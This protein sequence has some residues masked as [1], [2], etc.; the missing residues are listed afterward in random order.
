MYNHS[1]AYKKVSY[2]KQIACQLRTQ[3]VDGI[4]SNYGTLKS[5]LQVTLCHWKWHHSIDRIRVPISIPQQL[6][7]YLVLFARYSDLLV[8]N[9][10]IFIPH[11]YLASP[12][13][14]P[15]R[16]FAKMFDTHKT[17][18]IGLPRGEETMTICYAISIKYLNVTNRQ[19]YRL[20]TV[21]CWRAIKTQQ[22]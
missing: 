21:L 15:H 4:S 18:M 3:Y 22:D 14:W 8:E 1:E 6:W 12:R 2:R 11:L 16:N 10:K 5:W 7:C 17:R 20:Q 13:G 9:R 19:T